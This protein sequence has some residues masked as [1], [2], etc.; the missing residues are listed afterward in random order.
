M[1]EMIHSPDL[2]R[3]V[4]GSD[5][6]SF[7]LASREGEEPVFPQACEGVLLSAGNEFHK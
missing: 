4:L 1:I 5:R 3:T 6:A 7:V 2:Q